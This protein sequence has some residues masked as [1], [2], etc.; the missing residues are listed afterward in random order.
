M[1][2]P[3][4]ALNHSNHLNSLQLNLL[5][6]AQHNRDDDDDND[7]ESDL[8]DSDSG[9]EVVEEPTL[10]PSELAR[11]NHNRTLSTI[12]GAYHNSNGAIRMQL[13]AQ[14]SP[15][16]PPPIVSQF[17]QIYAASNLQNRIESAI[18]FQ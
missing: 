12:S 18:N 8:A 17:K 1:P 9:L 4:K 11:G 7:D 15:F 13:Q 5:E 16:F 14:V 2:P 3:L 6:N 10:R